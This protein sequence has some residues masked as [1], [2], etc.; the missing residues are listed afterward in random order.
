MAQQTTCPLCD[1]EASYHRLY[2]HLQTHH[3]KSDL[4]RALLDEVDGSGA[5]PQSGYDHPD[6][7]EPAV[8]PT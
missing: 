2:T 4:S 5:I 1:R 7:R 6:R 3:C 8:N